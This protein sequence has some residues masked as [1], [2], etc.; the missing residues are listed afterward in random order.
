M[1]L[2]LVGRGRC[3]AQCLVL[4]LCPDVRHRVGHRGRC[5]EPCPEGQPLH[6]VRLQQGG[7]GLRLLC[8]L[9]HEGLLQVVPLADAKLIFMRDNNASNTGADS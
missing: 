9:L 5:G 1:G 4:G 7:E 8:V 2:A 6:E 3:D